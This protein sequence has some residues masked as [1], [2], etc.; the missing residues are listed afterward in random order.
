MKHRRRGFGLIEATAALVLLAA[1]ATLVAQ[2]VAWS[3]AE[4]RASQRRTIALVEAANAMER[5]AA[6]NPQSL[7]AH[8]ITEMPL[9]PTTKE[10]LPS[11]RLTSEIQ[12]ATGALEGKR[13]VIEV[14][15]LNQA[16]EP[17]MPV[18]FVTWVWEKG[19]GARD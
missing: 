17:E 1:M 16:G 3:A 14:N 9:S 10:M 5:L 12:A 2:I 13:I 18:R 4:C 15:W 6:S 7:G 19:S 8:S 11:G